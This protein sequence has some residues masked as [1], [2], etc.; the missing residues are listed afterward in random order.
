MPQPT[1][2]LPTTSERAE[3]RVELATVAVT[4]RDHSQVVR[5]KG[6]LLSARCTARTRTAGGLLAL[7]AGL[8]RALA[9]VR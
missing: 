7:Q 9:V 5:C 4:E 6:R 2:P 3:S 8:L 1:D